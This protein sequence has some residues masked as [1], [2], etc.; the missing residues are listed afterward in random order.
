MGESEISLPPRSTRCASSSISRSAQRSTAPGC[1]R[2]ERRSTAF[3]ARDELLEAERLDEVV[4]AAEREAAHLVL[5]RVLRGEEQYGDPS[6][7]GAQPPADLEAVEVGE[8][9][10]EDDEVGLDGRGGR[11]RVA[12]VRH[13]VDVEA[14]VAQGRL[15]HRTQVVLVVD[16]QK[17]FSGHESNIAS[18]PGS[19]LRPTRETALTGRARCARRSLT[20]QAP[21]EAAP[22]APLARSGGNGGRFRSAPARRVRS[23]GSRR[24][25]RPRPG[26]G[27]TRAAVGRTGRRPTASEPAARRP[28]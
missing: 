5:G 9:H 11:E 21:I 2:P 14:E 4:V 1:A 19:F 3:T 24:R 28:T 10:V 18:L 8:H 20:P 26:R 12:P 25:P 22:L 16:E 13:G 23:G 27:P 15:E 6:A 17:A 7:L